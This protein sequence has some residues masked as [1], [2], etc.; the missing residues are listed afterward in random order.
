LAI[1]DGAIPVENCGTIGVRIE[2][3]VVVRPDAFTDDEIGNTVAIDIG[4]GRSM[5]L[6]KSYSP[7]LPV[8]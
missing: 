2:I 8:L 3:V 5:Q 6:R 1:T 7:A 4:D